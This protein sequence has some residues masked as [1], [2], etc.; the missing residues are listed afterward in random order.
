ML[1]HFARRL[2]PLVGGRSVAVVGV[3][4]RQYRPSL[5][6]SSVCSTTSMMTT[7]SSCIVPTICHRMLSSSSSS[8]TPT[9]TPTH[10]NTTTT[11]DASSERFAEPSPYVESVPRHLRKA[12]YPFSSI[13][14][15]VELV[16]SLPVENTVHEDTPAYFQELGVQT[17]LSVPIEE[18]EAHVPVYV[19]T[20]E[21]HSDHDT[22]KWRR[23]QRKVVLTGYWNEMN[24]S[25]A[26]EQVF[27]QL[28]GPRVHKKY[29]KLTCDD[30][31]TQDENQEKVFRMFSELL[32][33]SKRLAIELTEQQQSS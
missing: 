9:L 25:P 16:R 33:E 27:R 32:S 22:P 13:A 31:M 30:L 18:W 10:T 20:V 19:D 4:A 5:T 29:F 28:L 15:N 7:Q 2:A 8:N 26:Q 17:P 12:K 14:E 23:V 21:S 1:S 6:Q 11:T 24:M 3:I